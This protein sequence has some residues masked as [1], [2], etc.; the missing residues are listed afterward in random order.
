MSSSDKILIVEDSEETILFLQQ[1]LEDHGFSY[2]VTRNGSEALAAMDAE[3][4][5]LVLLD[6][7]M[8]KKSGAT[9]LR[10][11]KSAPEFQDIP[12]VVVTGTGEITGVDMRTG[13]EAEKESYKDDFNRAMGQELRG[14]IFRL[15]PDGFID[16]PIDPPR[17][18]EKIRE[19]VP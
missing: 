16:K 3:R 19:L 12:V 14:R 2:T 15:E 8:P 17:L 5:A 1:I 4:P 7:M 9:V 11:M 13:E 10:R 18:V 6:I